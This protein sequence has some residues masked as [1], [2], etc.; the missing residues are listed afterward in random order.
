MSAFLLCVGC[1]VVAMEGLKDAESQ[2]FDVIVDPGQERLNGVWSG[3]GAGG[4]GGGERRRPREDDRR[5]AGV[6]QPQNLSDIHSKS[7]YFDGRLETGKL[8]FVPS[9]SAKMIKPRQTEKSGTD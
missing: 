5:R 3:V 4:G 8:N 1:V 2:T 9:M 6:T 7:S